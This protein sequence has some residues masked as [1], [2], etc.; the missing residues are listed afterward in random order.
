ML[1]GLGNLL[2]SPAYGSN[3]YNPGFNQSPLNLLGSGLNSNP[4]LF[5]AGGANPLL[6]GGSN[7]L[8]GG[9]SNPL[10]GGGSNSLL[11]GGLNPL[12]SLLSGGLKSSQNEQR[13]MQEKAQRNLLKRFLT[14]QT[15]DPIQS[16][17]ISSTIPGK[18][19]LDD[20]DV[21]L[22]TK[23]D[24][25]RQL[26]LPG[27]TNPSLLNSNLLGNN[28][29]SLGNLSS[30]GSLASLANSNNNNGGLLSSLIGMAGTPNN[31]RNILSSLG[32]LGTG[33]L[34]GGNTG[35]SG[36]LGSLQSGMNTLNTLN[37]VSNAVNSVKGLFG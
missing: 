29:S 22:G 27:N 28:R 33:L 25:L 4:G 31:N 16:S 26:G 7:P 18:G 13:L 8:L 12:S 1:Q 36:L 34:G 15:G 9:G 17:L 24:I 21:G 5:G 6:G 10:L 30:L 11:G 23:S 35:G 2:G 19:A 37:K 32:G 14:Q 20:F 3:T